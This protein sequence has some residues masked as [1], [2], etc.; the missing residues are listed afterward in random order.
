MKGTTTKITIACALFGKTQRA[1]LA[2]FFVHPQQSFYLRQ[3][4]R[5]TGIGQGAAQRELA[6]WVEAGLLVRNQQGRQVYFQ[7]NRESPAFPELKG[8]AVKTSGVADILKQ[9][10]TALTGRVSVAF[11]YGSLACGNEK[12]DSDIDVLVVGKAAF[13]EVA[14]ALT[15]AEGALGREINPTVYTE[16]EFRE[17]LKAGH[18][19]LKSVNTGPKLFLVGSE[20]EFKR[21]GA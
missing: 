14:A 21:L 8:L 15:P 7:A 1:L 9:S 6:K 3:I 19:F 4:L 11:V 13:R 17:K 2:L 18:H 10:L 5:L 20:N 12:E 16:R